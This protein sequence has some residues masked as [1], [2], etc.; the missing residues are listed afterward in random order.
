MTAS[1]VYNK[2]DKTA[3][4]AFDGTLGKKAFREVSTIFLMILLHEGIKLPLSEPT[5]KHVDH[6]WYASIN[7]NHPL[8]KNRIWVQETAADW[9]E[10]FDNLHGQHLQAKFRWIDER[11]LHMKAYLHKKAT[12]SR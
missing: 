9:A 1:D 2:L 10:H 7:P 3:Q 6:L 8:H 4:E 11:A 5:A 12:E